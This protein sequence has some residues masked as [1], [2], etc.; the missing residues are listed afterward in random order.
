LESLGEDVLVMNSKM[1]PKR[2][3][4]RG[5][6]E[7]ERRYLVKGGEDL[8]LDQRIEQ[9]FECMNAALACDAGCA[10]RGLR[11][12]TYRVLPMTLGIGLI[13]WVDNTQPLKEICED[14]IWEC[15]KSKPSR[16]SASAPQRREHCTL[17]HPKCPGTRKYVQW[18]RRVGAVDTRDPLLGM[19]N[20]RVYQKLMNIDARRVV[21]GFHEACEEVPKDLFRRRLL[22][23]TT[24]PEAFL[25]MRANFS[26]SYSALCIAG[27]VLGI[28]D[29]HLANFLLDKSDGS[30]V[31]IDFGISFSLGAKLPVPELIPMRLTPQ[32]TQLLRPLDT[33]SILSQTMVMTM[34]ALGKSKHE[35]LSV[36]EVFVREPLLEWMKFSDQQE[37]K[38]SKEGRTSEELGGTFEPQDEAAEKKK[39]KKKK[40]QWYPRKKVTTAAL[41][42]SK[43]N[44][45]AVM[46]RQEMQDEM[47]PIIKDS[48][49]YKKC[50][51]GEDVGAERCT[52]EHLEFCPSVELQVRY[53]IEMATD[54][55][56]LARQYW[57]LATWV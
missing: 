4:V 26:R 38:M 33:T 18:R 30:V 23:L 53:L 32:F 42:L 15:E 45:A 10:R 34:R 47:N 37:R 25:T 3:Q 11:L 55:N 7:R 40:S 22:S 28:G 14:S 31:G 29:R 50:V 2:I 5:S 20:P 44:P 8:R 35:L 57:G 19:Q 21:A 56:I 9:L 49:S 51:W 27:Y 46:I 24:G 36:M 6:D 43:A 1:K 39:K 12:R 52:P 41:K 48:R 17:T 54:P 13:E 16:K